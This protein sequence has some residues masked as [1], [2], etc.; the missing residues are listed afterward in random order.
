MK[1]E[2]GVRKRR[3]KLSIRKID[4]VRQKIDLFQYEKYVKTYLCDKKCAPDG[5]NGM[6]SP[7]GTLFSSYR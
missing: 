3:G 6:I 7:S 4:A 1:L 5:E 2:S